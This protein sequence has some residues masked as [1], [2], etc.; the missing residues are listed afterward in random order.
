[1]RESKSGAGSQG[2]QYDIEKFVPQKANYDTT[3]TKVSPWVRIGL[4][5]RIRQLVAFDRARVIELFGGSARHAEDANTLA[6]IRQQ[7]GFTG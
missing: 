6:T 5:N 3:E 1:M 2:N 4:R 7:I